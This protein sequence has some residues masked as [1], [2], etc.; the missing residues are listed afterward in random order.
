MIIGIWGQ[1]GTG[2]STLAVTLGKYL[3]KKGTVLII[4]TDLTQPTLPT[5]V[6]GKAIEPSGSIGRALNIG[7]QEATKYMHQDKKYNRLFYAGLTHQETILSYEYGFEATAFAEHFIDGCK[8]IADYIII[9]LSPQRTDPFLPL[10]ISRANAILMPFEPNSKGLCR[11]NSCTELIFQFKAM[12]KI[13]P[14]AAKAQS[15]HDIDKFEQ[16]ANIKFKAVIPYLKDVAMSFD[17]KKDVVDI[18]RYSRQVIKI[19]K[20]LE[21]Q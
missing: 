6:N 7:V 4:D 18:L 17:T 9:D 12:D 1:A 16:S 8:Q 13:T 11:H 10:V 20:L 2:N 19:I 3:T 5:Y 14:I 15:F 21:V